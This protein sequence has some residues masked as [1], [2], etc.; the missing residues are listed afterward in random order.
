MKKALGL[1]RLKSLKDK[2]FSL[3][4]VTALLLMSLCGRAQHFTPI[5]NYTAPDGIAVIQY[6]G[7]PYGSA[8]SLNTSRLVPGAVFF[9]TTD[10]SLYSWTGTQWIK[11][12][13]GGGGG[14]GTVTS[15]SVGNLSPL[16]TSS[17]A[18]STTT[19]AV[20]FALSNA[21]AFTLLGRATPTGAPSYLSSIDS[22]WIPTLHS[23]LYYNTKYSAIG[24]GWGISGNSGIS[25]ANFLG[26]TNNASFRFRT[27][28]VE[29]I[30]LDSL[31]NLKLNG[32]NTVASYAALFSI[33]SIEDPTNPFFYMTTVGGTSSALVIK[34]NNVAYSADGSGSNFGPLRI[35]SGSVDSFISVGAYKGQMFQSPNGFLFRV[36]SGT[37][38]YT[39]TIRNNNTT[40]LHMRG[41]GSV[42]FGDS[43]SRQ[44]AKVAITSTTQGFL[45]PRMTGAQMNAI[46]S[47][48]TGLEVYCSDSSA[49]CYFNGAVWIKFGTGGGGTP[50]GVTSVTRGLYMQN[51]GTNITGTGSMDVDTTAATGLNGVY[52]QLSDL[53]GYVP[54]TGA[55]GNLTL[56][57]HNLSA[58]GASIT[59]IGGNGYISLVAQSSPPTTPAATVQNV[60]AGA[61]GMFTIMGSN[62]FAESFSKAHLTASHITYYQDKDYTIGDSARIEDN[63]EKSVV[64][65]YPVNDTVYDLVT[66]DSTKIHI[67]FVDDKANILTSNVQISNT[68]NTTEN[69]VYTGTIPANSIGLNGHFDIIGLVSTPNNAN[70]KTFKVKFNGTT[71]L[72]RVSTTS[73]ADRWNFSIFNRNSLSAQIAP[74]SLSG[75]VVGGGTSGTAPATYTFNTG[76]AITVT[77]TIQNAVIGD[78]SAL[79]AFTII[80]YP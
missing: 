71:V 52:F 43:I 8:P 23:E 31:G 18:T 68:G 24:S 39:F 66:A 16:F 12:T 76:A 14:V 64:N 38:T 1:I 63:F 42:S 59:G 2:Y 80:A 74:S 60:Y 62:G 41:D 11:S 22:N 34:P 55:T 26:T 44:S 45:P 15:V 77:V 3:L 61:T 32:V 7:I 30:V 70:N 65:G 49:Y 21:A 13:G 37:P 4:I 10:S 50:G 53:P 69:T 47:P 75:Q 72:N 58:Q 46:A 33:R 25:S 73:A 78:S 51:S 29:R 48:A 17:V 54:Y 40:Y 67:N 57:A 56:G 9:K 5:H 28:N 36:P 79:E 20:T 27:N 19:P 35:A 6:L